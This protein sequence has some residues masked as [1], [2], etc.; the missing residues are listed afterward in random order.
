[1]LFIH[2]A[3]ACKFI[4][5]GC[6]LAVTPSISAQAVSSSAMNTLLPQPSS[7]S[8]QSGRLNLTPSFSFGATHF[9][10]V[11]LDAAITRTVAR[12]H[13]I[14][15]LTLDK[16]DP[17]S[18]SATVR[19]E[20]SGPGPSIPS[21]DQDEA[22]SLEIG[23]GDVQIQAATVTGAM[24]ALTT[25]TQL[26][27]TSGGASYLPAVQINDSPR[28][29]WRGLMVDCGRHFEP[30]PVIKRT[31]DGMAEVKLNV[32]H[33]HLTE[34][35]GFRIQSLAFPNLTGEGS[36]GLFYTQ[37]QARDIVAY[38]AERGIRVVPE[39]DMPG[40]TTAWF[41][42]YPDLASGP[43]PYTVQRRFG[44]HDPAID[45]TRESTYIFLDTFIGEMAAIFPDAYMHIGGDESNG[46]QWKSNPRIVAFM[47]EHD[48][49]DAAALQAYFNQRLLQILTKH[50]KHMIGWDEILNPALPKDVVIQSWRGTDSLAASARQGYQGILSAPYYLDGMKS[51]AEHY[52]ADPLPTSI[53]LTPEQR[54]LILGGEVCMW[55][56]QLDAHTIDSR[57]WPRTAAIAE[58]FW[59]PASV[60][61]VDDMYR[62]LDAESKRLAQLGLTHLSQEEFD[63]H[64][65]AG[66]RPIDPLRTFT[67]VLQPVSF[68]NR[69][70][71]QRTSQLTPLDRLVDTVR[72]DP[73]SRHEID[74]LVKQFISKPETHPAERAELQ[75][76]FTSWTVAGPLAAEITA[77]SPRMSDATARANQL[78]EL[79]QIGLTALHHLSENQPAPTGWTA[80]SLATIDAAA[81]PAALVRF[82]M[83]D[84]LRSLV[85]AV[86]AQ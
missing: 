44:V 28:F 42:G 5:F 4:L 27:Q 53:D 48:I 26:V 66:S 9:R 13:Q 45:P 70:D 74:L 56:E 63:L 67:S 65:L 34:D 36:D 1:M 69:Y 55:G 80:A 29:R 41:V 68:G 15:G 8:I 51:A 57:I 43:G 10:D 39:F 30:V 47:R 25:L 21:L 82:T 23:N 46:K 77:Q 60:V 11:R 59:S 52:L 73:T 16:V 76:I 86:P 6:C 2:P 83:L 85:Q 17:R 33:W 50:G 32:L 78:T 71:V 35:Q 3:S 7:L 18:K 38:A 79:G 20:V 72:P 12:L 54:A 61:D 22:Y 75:R 81:K 31:L 64:E 62:R 84:P 58:R 40:H 19:V 49:K 24:R 37:D 14:T